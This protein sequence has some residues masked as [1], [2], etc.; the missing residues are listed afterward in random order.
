[1]A[2]LTIGNLIGS[3]IIA[4]LLGFVV[5]RSR[6]CMTGAI[7]DYFLFQITRNLKI[8][9]MILA[10][11]SF[12]YPLFLSY[13][14]YGG[15]ELLAL[16]QFKPT[17]VPGDWYSVVGGIIFGIGMALAGGCVTSTFYRIGEG[18]LNY[19]IVVVMM[20]FGIFIGSYLYDAFP[21]LMPGANPSPLLHLP[22]AGLVWLNDLLGINPA[23]LGIIQAAIFAFAYYRVAKSEA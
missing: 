14:Y 19:L 9:F 23:I 21:G 8:V 15:G 18:S 10:V 11:L 2:D 17:P 22:N 12:V 13:G 7:R 6:F 16:N 1:M 3:A 4:F 5:Q 20:L